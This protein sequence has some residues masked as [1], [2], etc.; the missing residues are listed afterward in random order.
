MTSAY[1]QLEARFHKA[2]VIGDSLS[3]LHWDMATMM[4][5]GSA[6]SRAEQ[7]AVLRG[8]HHQIL[9]APDLPDLL[10]AAGTEP[11]DAWERANLAEMRRDWI[12]TAALPADLVEAVTR[13]EAACEM[14]WREARAA[15]DFAQVLPSLKALLALVREVGAVKAERLGVGLYDALLDQYEPGGR[16]AAIDPVF[17]HLEGFLPGFLAEVLE[18]Q[19]YNPPPAPPPGPFPVE[20][21]RTLGLDM[22]TRLGFDFNRGRLDVSHHP[23]CGG[24][25]D[26]TR[27]TTRYDE[28]D[29]VS[30]LMGVIHETGHALYEFGLPGGRWRHQPVGRARGMVMHESQ[31]LLFEMQVARSRAF[32]T[33]AAPAIRAAFDSDGPAWDAE[34]LYRRGI[35][36]EPGFIRVDA[37]E[38]TYPAHVIIR[39]RLERALIEGRMELEDLPAAWNEGYGRLLGITPP[40]DRLGCLQDIHWYSGSWGYFPTY[41][42]GAMT[43]A[44]VFDAA[45]RAIPGMTDALSRGEVR[46]LLDW[47]RAE[48][49]GKASS[50][51]T[52][53]LMVAATGRPLDPAVFAAHLRGRYLP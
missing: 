35:K 40:N 33:F 15:A 4:P 39:Y 27:I 43:A 45:R 37:D 44:Q 12:H 48:I 18:A 1:A 21:Q 16:A 50:L 49:H 24:H 41:T 2:S 25:A 20:C 8:L 6:E 17:D 31:S 53:D 28:T 47:L 52:T 14:V 10:D 51:S 32:A 9:A 13:A 19:S 29:F 11:L 3:I 42:L 38:V 46:P 7:F 30:A 34:A 23:F 26:D 22:M 36:V 5:D